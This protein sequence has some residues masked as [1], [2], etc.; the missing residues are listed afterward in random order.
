MANAGHLPPLIKKADGTVRKLPAAGS[1]PLGI[2]PTLS[3]TGQSASLEAGDTIVL[4]TDGIIEAMNARDELYGY[5]R[6]ESLIAI[7]PADPDAM[8]AAIVEDV[9]RFTGLSPQHDDM[10]LVC[11]GAIP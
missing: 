7:S 2:L 10:T 9:N 3:F 4:Y 8:K 5:E 11:F 6:L 1:A